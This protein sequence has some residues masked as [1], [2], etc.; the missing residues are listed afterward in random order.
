MSPDWADP[1]SADLTAERLFIAGALHEGEETLVLLAP[2]EPGFWAHLKAS[3]E[4]QDGG[5]DPV[6]RWS[7]RVIAQI[8]TAQGGRALFPFG[9]PPWHPF[10]SWALASGQFFAAPI[11]LLVHPRM[12][13]WASI[14]GAIALPGHLPL[15][16]PAA[17]PC[18]GC[19]A[20]CTTACPAGALGRDGYDVPACHDFLNG[21][22][23]DSCLSEG[24]LARRAC[25]AS[26]SCGRLAEQSAWHM[27]H[28][29]R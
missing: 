24:C 2:A 18:T 1:L 17:D 23:A 9:G 26:A 20:P 3:P 22:T 5:A 27:R 25:P 29:H 12:G 16:A 14:R 11:R 8:A 19:P 6:D 13:L 7:E 4:W 21:P 10:Y 15:A 28:F